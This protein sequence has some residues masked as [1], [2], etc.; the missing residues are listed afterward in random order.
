MI[1]WTISAAKTRATSGQA[2]QRVGA[3]IAIA[4]LIAIAIVL[5]AVGHL[6]PDVSWLLT[7]GDK[8]IAGER[9]YVDF[10]EVNPPASILVYLPAILIGNVL[11]LPSEAVV[12]FLVFSASFASLAL[13]AALLRAA[14]LVE[15]GELIW[16]AFVALAVLLVLP[17]DAFAQR[18]H[19]ALIAS[20]PILCVYAC[21]ASGQNVGRIF[22]SLAGIGGG[23]MFAIKPHLALALLLPSTY[24]LIRRREGFRA[25][26]ALALAPENLAVCAVALLYAIVVVTLFPG[27]VSNALPVATT[28]YIPL[29][30][31]VTALIANPSTLLFAGAAILA[32][33]LAA[34]DIAKPICAVPL[35]GAL[36]FTLAAIIQGKGWPYHGYP[37]VALS[38]LATGILI[39][40]AATAERLSA[41]TFAIGAALVLHFCAGYLWFGANDGKPDLQQAVVE[42][43]PANP[44]LL[45]IS[46]DIG[47]GHPLVRLIHGRWV[48]TTCSLWMTISGQQLL[49][50]Y[51]DIKTAARIRADMRLDRRFLLHDIETGRPDVILVDNRRLLD[52]E[53]SDPGIRAALAPYHTA[54]TVDGVEIWLRRSG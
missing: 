16:L 15:R 9:P 35:L 8:L 54:R 37:G 3:V 24:L 30:L 26:A 11:H 44:R 13:C 38:E 12:V 45:T 25:A 48:G 43:A 20:L 1:G 22:A 5:R 18:E 21:R 47:L 10:L 23:I 7:V 28:V 14:H 2:L 17:S 27:F 6:S 31:P 19:I 40:Q 29:M 52:W 51:P 42:L 50:Q 39:V 4:S 53:L 41:R 34:S 33:M 36:G 32:V 46:T 49:S